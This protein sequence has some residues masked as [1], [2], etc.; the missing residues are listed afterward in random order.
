MRRIGASA[1]LAAAAA[2]LPAVAHADY[3]SGM[4]HYDRGEYDKAFTEWNAS[5]KD[6]DPRV[7]YWLGVLAESG[8]GTD[9]NEEKAAERFRS[10]ADAG[11][12]QAQSALGYM[13][14]RGIGVDRDVQAGCGWWLLAAVQGLAPAQ[15]GVAM[16]YEMGYGFEKNP[17]EA[18]FWYKQAA[19]R[20]SQEAQTK[21]NA[22]EVAGA[23]DRSGSEDAPVQVGDAGDA[24]H[25]PSAQVAVSESLPEEP[26]V[27]EDDALRTAVLE[28]P[29]RAPEPQPAPAAVQIAAAEPEPAPTS[30]PV[31]L[32][33]TRPRPTA[34]ASARASL[35][36]TAPLAPAPA[37]KKATPVV[38]RMDAGQGAVQVWLASVFSQEQVNAEWHRL[39]THY[40]PHI[41]SLAAPIVVQ[42][43]TAKGHVW[44]IYA[45]PL[46][47]AQAED[48][49]SF[50]HSSFASATCISQTYK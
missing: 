23:T 26:A 11:F 13:Y 28:R 40:A 16:C 8:R 21:V 41:D 10:A 1:L 44:R 32:I 47:P 46:Q 29:E 9:K 25:A 20:G 33:E 5:A 42:A 17:D 14:T 7:S 4:T 50:V 35:P 39:Q 37:P 3:L 34:V 6:G 2:F 15:Y 22:L 31:Q 30:A 48:L 12:P 36:A 49:C 27:S 18:L 19:A 45:G 24:W 38:H 43:D